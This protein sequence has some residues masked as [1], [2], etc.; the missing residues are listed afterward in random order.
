MHVR[1]RFRCGE[2]AFEQVC[3]RVCVSVRLGR[4]GGRA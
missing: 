1:Q 4:A 3:V 2:R